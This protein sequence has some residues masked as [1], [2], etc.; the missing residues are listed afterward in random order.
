V[1]LPAGEDATERAARSSLLASALTDP[2]SR[3]GVGVGLVQTADVIPSDLS[4]PSVPD[5]PARIGWVLLLA[6]LDDEEDEVAHPTATSLGAQLQHLTKLDDYGTVLARLARTRGFVAA[7]HQILR[8][9]HLSDMPIPASALQLCRAWFEPRRQEMEQP[10]G[11]ARAAA[12]HLVPI[13]LSVYGGRPGSQGNRAACLD[14]LDELIEAGV[15]E[16][17]R[18]ADDAEPSA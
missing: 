16:A 11:G 3:H 10:G 8:G 17:S 4:Q 5:A 1:L 6:L 12:Q 9:V 18:A 15:G 7:G 2:V 14:L 13:V